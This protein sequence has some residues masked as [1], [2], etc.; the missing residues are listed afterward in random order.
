MGSHGARP[1][2]EEQ[3]LENGGIDNMG[4]NDTTNSG[5]IQSPPDTPNTTTETDVAGPK[6]ICSPQVS[7]DNHPDNVDATISPFGFKYKCSSPSKLVGPRNVY[8][9]SSA[10][11]TSYTSHSDGDSLDASL[12]N[13]LGLP[14]VKQKKSKTSLGARAREKKILASIRNFLIV[15]ALSIHSVFEGMAIGLQLNV[16]DVWKLFAAIAIHAVAILFSIGAE[17]VYSGTKRLQIIFYMI[18]LSLVTPLGVIIGMVITEYVDSQSA[19]QIFIIGILQGL[20]GGTLLYITFFEVLDRDKLS[21]LGLTSLYGCFLLILG[22]GIMAGIEAAGAHSHGI[23]SHDHDHGHD[24]GHNHHGHHHPGVVDQDQLR[25]IDPRLPDILKTHNHNHEHDHDHDHGE[26]DPEHSEYDHEHDHEHNHD[27]DHEDDHDH[28]HDH[29]HNHEHNHDHEEADPEHSE[30]D[31]NH[32]HEDNHNHELDHD[33][34]HN[35]DHEDDHNNEHDHDPHDEHNHQ[36]NHDEHN[37]NEHNHKAHEE[38]DPEHDEHD[39]DEHDE[40]ENTTYFP[41]PV[42][43]KA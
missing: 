36:H 26:A 37:H 12:P 18:T 10:T 20:A 2:T 32:N 16:S 8:N 17:M 4:F 5:P 9:V 6:T 14:V 13:H 1:K 34:E 24:H 23:M 29:E 28:E 39:H 3:N 43:Q 33:H 21:K 38:T 27:H 11:L 30:H 35:H 31:H 22:F 15:L 25:Q 19:T 41:T 7:Q 40:L 42:R